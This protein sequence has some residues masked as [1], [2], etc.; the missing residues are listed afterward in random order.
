MSATVGSPVAVALCGVRF[1]YDNGDTWAL[2]EIDLTIHS[3]ERVCVTGPNGSGKSTLA[4]VIAGLA[5]PDA[6]IVTLLDETVFDGTPHPDAYRNARRGIGAVFQ[7]PEDQIV[8]TVVED[9]VAFGPE[10]LGV[11]HDDIGRRIVASLRA[12]GMTAARAA[13][14][15]VMSGGQQQRIAIAGTMAMDP[16]MVVFDEPTAML[17]TEARVEVMTILDTLQSHSV[18]IVHITHHAE[19]TRN[20]DRVIRMESGR[21]VSDVADTTGP[22]TPPVPDDEA[23][24]PQASVDTDAVASEEPIIT[25]DQLSFAYPNS[26]H[27]VIDGCSFIVRRGETVAIMGHNGAGKSTLARLLCAL[28]RPSGGSITIAGI[29]VAT[30]GAHGVRG[31]SRRDRRRLRAHIGYVMQHPERQLFA[32]TVAQDV[33]YGPRNQGL[34]DDEV[35]AR[36]DQALRMLRIEHLA[37]RSPFALSGGQQRLVAIAGV[38]ACHPDV[39]VMDE[40]TA[41]LDAAATTRIHGLIRELRQRNVT[42]LIITHEAVEA[43]TLADR[44]I[45]IGSTPS[46]SPD[47]E[48]GPA[49]TVP[50]SLL[51][52]LDPRVTMVSFLV[53]MFT[54]FAITTPWQLA[55]AALLTLGL[56]AAGRLRPLRL[57][58]SVRLILGMLVIMGLLNIFVARGGMTLASWG[59]FAITTGGL[60][61]AALYTL[62]FALVVLLGAIMLETTTPTALTDAVGSLLSPLRRLGV[63]TQEIALVLSLALRFLPTLASE[64]RAIVDAQSARGGEVETGSPAKRVRALAAIVVPVF[65]GTLRHADNLALALDARCYEEGVRRTHWRVLRVRRRDLVFI[66][67]VVLYLAASTV[68]AIL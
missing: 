8:T 33:A 39:L 20:A 50:R 60:S 9:D 64:T 7:H 66:A 56:M 27:P 30:D 52:S 35:H 16:A 54:A 18:T 26:I 34:D 47:D 25:V 14:P 31:A 45:T 37:D 63:H 55:L 29:P 62:R 57:L 17:D 6:G 38:I 59:P 32:D 28:E 13:D 61:I 5:A 41:S 42:V 49:E 19:E 3:G 15:T 65:A 44:T 24:V 58:R 68:L 10:N 46:E 23:T 48:A 53:L 22:V 36:V 40:P 4:R 43:E 12:V 21:I 2:D 11:A 67:V 1:S 51:A